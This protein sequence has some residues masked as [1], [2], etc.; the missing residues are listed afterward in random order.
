MAHL[1]PIRDEAG[2]IVDLRPQGEASQFTATLAETMAAVG[3]G[4][5]TPAAMPAPGSSMPPALGR[6]QVAMIVVGLVAAI[7]LVGALNL[8]RSPAAP[9]PSPAPTAVPVLTSTPA[10]TTT[11]TPTATPT[12]TPAPTPEP[13]TPIVIIQPPPPPIQCY[14]VRLDVTDERGIPIGIAEGYSCESYEAAQANA[15]AQAE[16][17]KATH[18]RR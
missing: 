6:H 14:T 16:Q 7:A 2:A 18:Q 11:P 12:S 3:A 4:E 15:A 17:V 8:V 9:A 13:P 1:T 10:P 5:A